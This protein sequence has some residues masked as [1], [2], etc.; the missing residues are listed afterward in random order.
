MQDFPGLPPFPTDVEPINLPILDWGK[1]LV[2]DES[3]SES[4]FAACKDHGIFQLDLKNTE[5]G[6]ML[7][8]DVDRLF[9][10]TKELF[11]VSLEEKEKYKLL[12]KTSFG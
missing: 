11:E 3:E 12:A 4:L 8:E 10:F 6:S 9:S 5:T 7:L 1:L 2:R